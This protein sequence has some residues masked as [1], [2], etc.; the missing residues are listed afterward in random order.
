MLHCDY[1][2]EHVGSPTLAALTEYEKKMFLQCVY[3]NI[4]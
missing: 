3:K 1:E 2:V 4:C